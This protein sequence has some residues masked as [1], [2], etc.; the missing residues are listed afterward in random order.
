[1]DFYK[2]LQSAEEFLFEIMM[3]VLLFPRTL[4]VIFTRPGTLPAYIHQ[5]LREKDHLRFDD[6]ISPPI[7]LFIAVALGGV[8]DSSGDESMK[9]LNTLGQWL[10]GNYYN[11]VMASAVV[12]AIPPLFI[13]KGVMA[14]R[15]EPLQRDSYREPFY[16][17]AFLACP[18]ALL[19]PAFI[20]MANI[21]GWPPMVWTF[22]LLLTVLLFWYLAV[23]LRYIHAAI[24]CGWFRAAL[25][26]GIA[27][28]KAL[29]LLILFLLALSNLAELFKVELVTN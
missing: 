22:N 12:F 29:G 1:M 25:I 17:Q 23:N 16:F 7:C 14:A 4:R 10:T 11:N 20:Y 6:L 15:R 18:L 13:T 5:E 24:P 2:L 9:V 21:T 3:W 27:L 8:F 28:L 26:L 19:V